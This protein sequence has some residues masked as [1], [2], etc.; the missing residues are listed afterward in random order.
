[1]TQTATEPS[2]RGWWSQHLRTYNVRLALATLLVF[3]AHIW[4][5][6]TKAE[7]TGFTLAY[8]F[9]SYLVSIGLANLGYLA[10]SIGEKI[11]KPAYRGTYRT[12][13]YNLSFWFFV[14]LIFL[15]PVI[16]GS[17]IVMGGST[18]R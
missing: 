4:I 5:L 6:V 13:A 1:M 18:A 16:V 7:I 10:G 2:E 15:S 12:V 14:V 11:L 9:L 8:M 3:A 17:I